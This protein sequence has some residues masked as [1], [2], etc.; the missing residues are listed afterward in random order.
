MRNGRKIRVTLLGVILLFILAGCRIA[1]VKQETVIS[2]ER[3]E[4]INFM[5]VQ[6]EESIM[7]EEEKN[8]VDDEIKFP[9]ME[10]ALFLDT[11]I[12]FGAS[13]SYHRYGVYGDFTKTV[14]EGEELYFSLCEKMLGTKLYL[15]NAEEWVFNREYHLQS[16]SSDLAWFVGR[17]YLKGAS[18]ESYHDTVYHQGE[19]FAEGKSEEYIEHFQYLFSEQKEGG[20]TVLSQEK[21]D[22]RKTLVDKLWDWNKVMDR[23]SS[24][25]RAGTLLAISEQKTNDIF[26]YSLEDYRQLY[27]FTLEE[28]EEDFFVEI[29]QVEGTK[30]EGWIVFSNGTNSWRMDFPQGNIVKLGEFMYGTTYSPNGQ[31][32]AYCTGNELLLEQCRMLQEERPEKIEE[33]FKTW[34]AILPGWYIEDLS[35]GE[36]A[37][38]RIETDGEHLYGGHCTWIEKDK[39]TENVGELEADE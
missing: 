2:T 27:R 10:Y 18:P 1:K 3:K 13:L 30:E 5:E 39:L 11:E 4:I 35:T 24:I 36:K 23:V 6:M 28:L 17:Q 32:L 7:E 34:N 21:M 20:F 25:N 22:F 8:K 33:L 15:S 38:I 26:I 19:L 16:L 9:T 31:Y 14:G 29:S 12:E 37:Y